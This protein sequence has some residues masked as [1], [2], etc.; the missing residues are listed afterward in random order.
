MVVV[1]TSSCCA[2]R[3]VVWR[4]SDGRLAR[5]LKAMDVVLAPFTRELLPAVQP[6]FEHPEVV[7]R[8]GG[9]QWP[10]RNLELAGTGLGETFRGRRVLRDH[11]WVAYDSS[12]AVVANIGGEV[13]DRWCR[14]S[15]GPDGAVIEA[16][17]PGLSMGLAYVV[18]PRRWGQGFGT[19]ALLAV[20]AAPEVADVVLFAA[21]VEPDNVASVRCAAAAGMR[22]DRSEPDWEG[23]VYCIRRRA[24]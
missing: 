22:P 21:G 11:S 5:T 7:R 23:F 3:P 6:W 2:T 18:D 16:V 17:E 12:G 9:P 10:V 24:R 19:A 1:M 20:T 15:E 4:Y 14:Y 13:Y 8:L